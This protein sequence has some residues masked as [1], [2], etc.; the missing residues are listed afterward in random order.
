MALIRPTAEH[1]AGLKLI[2]DRYGNRDFLQREVID[3]VPNKI[4]RKL[5][6]YNFIMKDGKYKLVTPSPTNP[7]RDNVHFI[8]I[9]RLNL[10][11][12]LVRDYVEYNYME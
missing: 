10:N 5:C 1:R 3:K 4:F 2:Y 11:D 12:H 7:K 6:N 9:Y 8:N